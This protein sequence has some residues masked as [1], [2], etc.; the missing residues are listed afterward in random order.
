MDALPLTLRTAVAAKHLLE[1]TLPAK[2]Q[3]LIRGE[4]AL[5]VFN[6]HSG[7]SYSCVWSGSLS[8]SLLLECLGRWRQLGEPTWADVE[9]RML[10]EGDLP[11]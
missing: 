5:Q 9:A 4:G 2:Y 8:S 7:A 10:R 3:I 11:L 6:K 1:E